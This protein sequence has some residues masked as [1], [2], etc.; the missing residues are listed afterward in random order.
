[1]RLWPIACLGVGLFGGLSS[2]SGH[3]SDQVQT[4]VLYGNMEGSL[5]PCGCT[6]PMS[7]GIVRAATVMRQL[8][9]S[10][11]AHLVVLGGYVTGR[12]R[13]DEL[14]VETLGEF[15]R[16]VKA[17]G[18]ELSD[19][20]AALGPGELVEMDQLSDHALFSSSMENAALVQVKP[21]VHTGEFLVASLSGS[22]EKVSA[23]VQGQPVSKNESISDLIESAKGSGSVAVLVTEEDDTGAAELARRYPALDVIVYRSTTDPPGNPL[24][25][26]DTTLVTTGFH[27]KEVVS[28]TF[29]GRRRSRYDVFA[30]GPEVAGDR[31]ASELY[32]SYLQRVGDEHLLEAWPR[33]KT[34][35][36]AGSQ[37][38]ASCHEDAYHV[39]AASGHARAFRDL[40]SKGHELDPDCVSC[41]VVG[42]S[43]FQGFYSAM[44][45]PQLAAVGC[46]S[47][48]GPGAAHSLAPRQV[49]IKRISFRVCD[50]CHTPDNS[51][52]FDVKKF[53]PLIR[54]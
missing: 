2:L 19:D 31:S 54:H 26:G 33:S 30:L 3:R 43:S 44:K 22:P 39:W 50:S 41:H 4:L 24:I 17:A 15:A 49:S 12:T 27:G 40:R 6:N 8:S 52:D 10:G 45:T 32:K 23:P 51:P 9:G 34:A 16:S 29:D 48:H 1:M 13:Q 14:K 38:C 47:C 11:G 37:T 21:I 7:G 46:E 53:W 28:L 5:A 20:V 25:V 42:L 35:S 18:L 36:Y